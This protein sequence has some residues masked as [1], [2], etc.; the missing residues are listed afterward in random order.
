MG[1]NVKFVLFPHLRYG[2]CLA[3]QPRAVHAIILGSQLLHR[4]VVGK[5]IP[6]VSFLLAL[7]PLARPVLSVSPSPFRRSSPRTEPVWARGLFLDM[8]ACVRLSRSGYREV[9]R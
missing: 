2:W 8:T 6:Q 5:V 7:L 9:N 3:E 1:K 4:D